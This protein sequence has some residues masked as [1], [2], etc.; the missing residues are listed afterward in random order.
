M[1]ED[2]RILEDL[3]KLRSEIESLEGADEASRRKLH[4][5]VED[6]EQRLEHANEASV[7]EED[8]TDQLK[9]TMLQFETS[10]P[11]LTGILN[12]IMIKLVNMGI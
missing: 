9:D 11:T 1:T 7:P 3:E 2:A 5:L 8:I 10:H 4:H 6:L 12:D